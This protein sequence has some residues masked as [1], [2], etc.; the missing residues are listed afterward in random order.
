[1]ATAKKEKQHALHLIPKEGGRPELIHADDVEDKRAAGYTDPTGMKANGD[2]WNDGE[3]ALLQQ[4]AASEVAK[5]RAERDSKRQEKA[6]EENQAAL[7]QQEE[8]KAQADARPDMKVQIV[9]PPKPEKAK[10]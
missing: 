5:N 2:K 4:D 9:D 8:V 10:K 7:K 6:D 3:E 1:M